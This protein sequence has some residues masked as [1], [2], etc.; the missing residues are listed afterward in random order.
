MPEAAPP[1]ASPS[2]RPSVDEVADEPRGTPTPEDPTP[3]SSA[4]PSPRQQLFAAETPA[5]AQERSAKMRAAEMSAYA[6]ARA[7]QQMDEDANATGPPR[8]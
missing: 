3:A 8:L 6:S 7:K 4:R 1:A 5:V 2:P